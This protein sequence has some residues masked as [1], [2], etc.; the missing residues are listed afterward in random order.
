MMHVLALSQ[1]VYASALAI[2][3]TSILIVLSCFI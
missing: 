2:T 1:R 3:G